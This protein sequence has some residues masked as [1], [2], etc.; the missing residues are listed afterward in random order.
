MNGANASVD[1]AS[2]VEEEE[3]ACA[4][5]GLPV[6]PSRRRGEGVIYC[7][8]G[9]RIAHEVA[10]VGEA[11]AGAGDGLAGGPNTL[12][13]RLGMGLFLT[14]NLM[15]FRWLF[16][17][18]E[19]YGTQAS[20]AALSP[21]AELFSYLM[22]LLC[23]A[24]VAL[25]WTPL[26]TDTIDNLW[27]RD[28]ANTT[29]W[30]PRFD[31]N[32]LIVMGTLAAFAISVVSTVRGDG[33]LYYETAAMILVLVTLG[34]YLDSTVKKRAASATM[35]LFESIPQRVT[36]RR[37][38]EYGKP[39]TVDIQALRPGWIVRVGVGE[40]VACD[41]R[42]VDGSAWVDESKLTGE[43]KPRSVTTGDTLL[44][45]SVSMDGLL[46]LRA[47]RVGEDRT[48]AQVR[49]LL[50]AAR[51]RQPAIQ[52][53]TDRVAAVFV[54]AV[55]ALAV[56][57]F[58][59]HA[60]HD[61]PMRGLMDALSVLLISCPCALGLAAP[62][63]TWSALARAAKHGVCIDCG[64]TIER[65]AAVDR[66]FFDKTGT[67]TESKM[68]LENLAVVNGV[69]AHQALTIAAAMEQAISHPIAG[70][71]ITAANERGATGMNPTSVRVLPGLGVEAELEGVRWRLGGERL[72]D[73]T[74]A[75][76]YWPAAS[77]AATRIYL[78]RDDQPAACFDLIEHTRESAAE[79]IRRLRASG[80]RVQVLTGDQ[81]GP[82]GRLGE[83]LG[84]AVR[85][86]LLPRDKVA[87]VERARVADRSHAVAMV[88]DGVNDAPVLAAADV[89]IAGAGATDLAHQ[90]GHVRIFAGGLDRVPLLFDIARHTMRRIRLNLLWAFSYNT[91]GLT[92]A[93]LG[94]LTPI[95]SALAMFGSS[96]LIVM[97]SRNAGQVPG[98]EHPHRATTCRLPPMR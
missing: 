38:G 43:S 25:L 20:A 93:T 64:V 29:R 45:G 13:V 72:I 17:A 12:F 19:I 35:R 18:Q 83:K 16:Y 47:Q 88:G 81:A 36:I 54:P 92:L 80:M 34:G 59:W 77:P 9:C 76:R 91:L 49:R 33:E 8:F 69:D 28:G 84:I 70:A 68:V 61:E 15:V 40:A 79:T 7:C 11:G 50:E 30:W 27:N 42:V 74:E 37:D 46:W 22:L 85:H 62:L 87:A 6:P 56:S 98:L 73:A 51:K 58:A 32:A 86:G 90:A 48:I 5:C 23:T 41:G 2:L 66:V 24:V 14:I 75:A 55:M 10:A 78:M 31:M 60:W 53:L 89:G 4:H 39:T 67:L 21:M 95:F 71:I 26:A 97:T 96:I 1:D 44:A 65:A 52:R 82:A 57:V 94:Y 3:N 63:A